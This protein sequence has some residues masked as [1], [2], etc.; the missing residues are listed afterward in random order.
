MTNKLSFKQS[1]TA[2]LWAAITAI[3]A[4]SILFFI[5]H[6]AGIITDTVVVQ[7]GTPLTVIPVIIT[8]LIPV[9]IAIV[10]FFLLEKYTRKGYKIVTIVSIVLFDFILSQ[11][12]FRNTGSSCSLCS[13]TYYNT[14]GSGSSTSLFY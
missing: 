7:P 8:S 3:L 14:C 9:L 4:N 10:V 13:C 5:Y 2:G 11:S 6:S 1:L 12:I